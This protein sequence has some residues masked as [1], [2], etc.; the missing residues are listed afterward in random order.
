MAA[1]FRRN[2]V[3][4]EHGHPPLNS[5]GQNMDI[6]SEHASEHGHPPLNSLTS[7]K[8]TAFPFNPEFCT[9]GCLI[10]THKAEMN[11]LFRQGGMGFPAGRRSE[12]SVEHRRPVRKGAGLL[13]HPPLSSPASKK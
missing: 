9:Y 5:L 2:K 6:E 11:A 4:P 8:H 13:G 1:Q 7:E 3:E 12:P 10:P